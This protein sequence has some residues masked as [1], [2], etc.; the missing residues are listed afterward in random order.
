MSKENLVKTWELL[1]PGDRNETVEEACEHIIR[2]GQCC[3]DE[4]GV[5]TWA[6]S[7]GSTPK[8]IF[9]KLS[10]EYKDRLDWG[11]VNLFWSDER[12]CA[13][14]H[15]DSNYRM[16]MDAG[17]QTLPIPENQIFRMQAEGAI[18]ENAQLYQEQILKVT[19][20]GSLDFVM[21]G[22]GDDGHTASLF[23]GTEALS[24][25]EDL[26]V[27]NYVPQQK[28]WRM[29]MTYPCIN[30]AKVI[31]V[32]VL[33]DGKAEM[34]KKVLNSSEEFPVQGVGSATTPATFFADRAAAAKLS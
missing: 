2:V 23:P 24:N 31:C 5:F 7:G 4:R 10:K 30:Q 18:E 21:L 14:D 15:P 29:T 6:L 28:A 16:A 13:P 11:R 26:V 12:S 19:P 33:G 1:V 27:A 34:L 9:Q 3:T 32:Y 22:M 20:G 25:Q 8:A 17:L